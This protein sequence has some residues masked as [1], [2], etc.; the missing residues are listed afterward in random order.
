MQYSSVLSIFVLLFLYTVEGVE[1]S[2]AYLHPSGDNLVGGDAPTAVAFPGESTIY[3]FGGQ[4]ANFSAQV[5][6]AHNAL[7]R[8]DLDTNHVTLL[9][10]WGTLPAPRTFHSSWKHGS[11]HLFIAG[12]ISYSYFFDTINVYN[13]FWMYKIGDNTWT[14]LTI[15][16][17]FP[18]LASFVAETGPD[19]SVY[20]FGGVDSSFVA[21]GD[22]YKFDISTNTITLLSPAGP[23]PDARYHAYHAPTED[24]FFLTGGVRTDQSYIEDYWFFNFYTQTWTQQTTP[25][26]ARPTNRTHSVTGRVG[27]HFLLGLGDGFGGVDCPGIIFGQNPLND[28]WVYEFNTNTFV[29]VNPSFAPFNKYS[30]DARLGANIYAFGGYSFDVN[31]CV[32]TYNN[33][34][35]RA[36]FGDFL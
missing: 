22:L 27:N 20:I 26:G 25:S 6:T 12:G 8:Y 21:H 16:G 35:L 1:V 5:N 11:N 10:P 15:T 29:Q 18:A 9:N 24:G 17:T 7:Y 32:Q 31:T 30:G 28:T 3:V 34:I 2:W 36:H 33:D 19:G 4:T 13:D 14:Q 23:K